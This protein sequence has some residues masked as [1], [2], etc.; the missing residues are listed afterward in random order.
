LY[1]VDRQ[2]GTYR[3]L[4]P[5]IKLQGNEDPTTLEIRP[6]GSRQASSLQMPRRATSRL[7]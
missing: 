6:R 4:S 7:I 5:E 3:A 1:S 2:D